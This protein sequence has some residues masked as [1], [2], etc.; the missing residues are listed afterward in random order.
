MQMQM[1]MQDENMC[2]CGQL[3]IFCSQ[4]LS[5]CLWYLF[6]IFYRLVASGRYAVTT[7][8]GKR[9]AGKALSSL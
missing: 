6:Y 1:Q 8:R 9:V 2:G 7:E 3:Y 5:F 4:F